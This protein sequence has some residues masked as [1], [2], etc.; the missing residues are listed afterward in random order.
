MVLRVADDGTISAPQVFSDALATIDRGTVDGGALS[1]HII[2]TGRTD[3]DAICTAQVDRLSMKGNCTDRYISGPRDWK[4]VASTTSG[5]LVITT[6]S[7][8]AAMPGI[9]YVQ[10]L[11]ASGGSG[12]YVW[13]ATGLPAGFTAGAGVI[14]S[15]GCPLVS[16]LMSYAVKLSVH[17]NTT[18]ETATSAQ[19]P[20][21]VNSLPVLLSPLRINQG[22]DLV[23][24]GAV[25]PLVFPT[26]Q[27]AEAMVDRMTLVESTVFLPQ[28]L[29]SCADS[30]QLP[31]VLLL[32]DLFGNTIQNVPQ[33]SSIG[34]LRNNG[35]LRW[36]TRLP[37]PSTSSLGISVS[38]DPTNSLGLVKPNEEIKESNL[39]FPQSLGRSVQYQFRRWGFDAVDEFKN[40]ITS[41][42]AY[43][44]GVFALPEDDPTAPQM[45]TIGQDFLPF[46]GSGEFVWMQFDEL[47]IDGHRQ[48]QVPERVICIVPSTW[49]TEHGY[50]DAFGNQNVIGM[51]SAINGYSAFVQE[52]TLSVVAHE[53]GHTYGFP[54]LYELDTNG[55]VS[56]PGP[57]ANPTGDGFWVQTGQASPATAFELMG[58]ANQKWISD[59]HFGDLLRNFQQSKPDPEMILVTGAVSPSGSITLWKVYKADA[60]T[61]TATAAGNGTVQILSRTGS[62]LAATTFDEKAQMTDTS[63]NQGPQDTPLTVALPFA[64][65]AF[66]IRV[67]VFDT[68]VATVNVGSRLLGDAVASI[69]DAGYDANPSQRQNALL[70]K[71]R[72]FDT[73]LSANAIE[74]ARN[75]LADDIRSALDAWLVDY[76]PSSRLQYSKVEILALVDELIRR[77]N[78]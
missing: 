24:A 77:L 23:S 49:F 19:L 68:P 14:V 13:S 5:P 33:S 43:M 50:T 39:I 61:P 3:V 55:D 27:S 73:Q 52:G 76:T 25:N 20:L 58:A 32:D 78:N 21:T 46:F 2:Y 34:A 75:N 4:F 64:S 57:A 9:P 12:N 45:Y 17:D 56:F 7:L 72:A 41:S 37:R 48:P 65:D 60:G 63:P 8:A 36:R 31:V 59:Q 71:I 11:T 6:S 62:V 26:S 67:L 51:A 10:A 38:V 66:Q 29:A 22:V 16:P 18:G 30:V 44:H 53:L 70:N 54:D 35:T 1:F 42:M 28:I 47:F 40:T 15:T 69:P 74:G